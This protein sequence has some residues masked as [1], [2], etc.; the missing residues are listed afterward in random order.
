MS[1]FPCCIPTAKSSKA[2]CHPRVSPATSLGP[3]AVHGSELLRPLSHAELA[4]LPPLAGRIDQETGCTAFRAGF[5]RCT[6][7]QDPG[8]LLL[9]ANK[10][11]AVSVY[12]G[13]G[14]L[15]VLP[16]FFMA[17]G[18]GIERITMG[19]RDTA[20]GQ[21]YSGDFTDGR[22]FRMLLRV[23]FFR[24]VIVPPDRY[25]VWAK[26]SELMQHATGAYISCMQDQLAAEQT[27]LHMRIEMSVRIGNHAYLQASAM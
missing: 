14:V 15:E 6:R 18:W 11:V 7:V 10:F 19:E 5:S 4:N 2:V 26:A 9:V 22:Q 1:I 24:T 20:S 21:L 3:N 12:D 16:Q 23:P 27:L 17:G 13:P 25:H 8:Y